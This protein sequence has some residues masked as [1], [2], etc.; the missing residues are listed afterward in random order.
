MLSYKQK[1]WKRT[2]LP[3]YGTEKVIETGDKIKNAHSFKTRAKF[4]LIQKSLVKSRKKESEVL[5]K[6]VKKYACL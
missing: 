1:N 4:G 3:H 5:S 2:I 6:S